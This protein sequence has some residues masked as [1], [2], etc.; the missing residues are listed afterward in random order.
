MKIIAYAGSFDV[1]TNGHLW[2]VKA[3]LEIADTMTIIVADNPAKKYYFPNYI[4]KQIIQNILIDEKLND[5]VN[6]IISSNE[7]VALRIAEYGITH[8]IR[9]IRNSVDF[10]QEK[11][12]QQ[13]N[14]TMFGGIKTIFVMPPAELESVSSSFIKG[15][16]GPSY[17]PSYVKVLVP[18]AT[19]NALMR[20]KVKDIF[21]QLFNPRN[22]MS[23]NQEY[24]NNHSDN[25]IID[26]LLFVFKS[27]EN[28][29]Y[30]Y[31]LS[32]IVNMLDYCK[33]IESSTIQ[34]K[35]FIAIL[36]H[37]LIQHNNAEYLVEYI[38]Y[39]I[40][41]EMWINKSYE[42]KSSLFVLYF[43]TLL[44]CE[45]YT[46]DIIQMIL[47]TAHFDINKI[48]S[49]PGQRE[50]IY[51]DLDIL[52]SPDFVYKEYI[53]NI[54]KEYSMF[55]DLDYK[56]GRIDVLDKLVNKI[57]TLPNNKQNQAIKNII[58]EKMFLS[59]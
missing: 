35:L 12:I 26:F 39:G 52:S 24:I 6:V 18:L 28:N 57:E 49:L 16:I 14:Y 46:K 10:D 15:L 21:L 47:S 13:A 9:G 25:K 5:R 40:N 11:L 59:N 58:N 1:F 8:M 54:R 4:R 22:F 19:G 42:E 34:K 53:N 50:L 7:Y 55:N 43:S 48:T 32:H 27:Y 41:K 44:G 45:E 23:L 2:V 29:R 20:M 37:D 33:D 38:N 17:W 36:L 31:D 3:G 56:K 51:A 30:Y